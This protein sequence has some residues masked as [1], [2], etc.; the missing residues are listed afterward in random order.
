AV[1]GECQPVAFSKSDVRTADGT[2]WN[3]LNQAQAVGVRQDGGQMN[4]VPA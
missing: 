3:L 1:N 2:F 4:S